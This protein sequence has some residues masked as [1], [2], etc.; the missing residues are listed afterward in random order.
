MIDSDGFRPNVGIVLCSAGGRLLWAKRIN[1]DA[2]QFP[3]GGIQRGESPREALF[4]ELHEELGL[5]PEH[6]QILGVTKGW[7]RYRLPGRYLRRGRGRLCIGQK[8]KWF[9]LRLVGDESAVRFDTTCKPEFDGWRWVD[10]WQPLDEVV[11]FKREV[12]RRALNELAPLIGV[13]PREPL[14]RNAIAA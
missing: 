2:W 9:A 5:L 10:Y 14:R 13:Q 6:V 4:R 8:Q 12:Y 11:E 7:L 3:Q 1:Q